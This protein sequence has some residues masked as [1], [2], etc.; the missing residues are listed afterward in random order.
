M[1]SK[2]RL[3]DVPPGIGGFRVLGGLT[4]AHLQRDRQGRCSLIWTVG[5]TNNTGIKLHL[6]FSF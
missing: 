6:T 2:P 1:I 3:T 5:L 4:G